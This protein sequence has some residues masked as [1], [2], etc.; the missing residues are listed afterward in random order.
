MK[1]ARKLFSTKLESITTHNFLIS[2]IHS[3]LSFPFY[4][5]FPSLQSP[6]SHIEDSPEDA[7]D[8]HEAGQEN[9]DRQKDL[10]R[11][12]SESESADRVTLNLCINLVYNFFVE[13]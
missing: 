12:E 9:A 3:W 1:E 2:V 10:V 13:Y 8:R 6:F 4:F 5:S 7:E 11:K